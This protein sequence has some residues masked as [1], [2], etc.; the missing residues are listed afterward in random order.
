MLFCWLHRSWFSTKIRK[1][2]SF[3]LLFYAN[4]MFQRTNKKIALVFDIM[5]FILWTTHTELLW[6]DRTQP[7]SSERYT[8]VKSRSF[9]SKIELSNSFSLCTEQ[10]E[11]HT[12]T[13]THDFRIPNFS[14][15]FPTQHNNHPSTH[16]NK[17]FHIAALEQ[18]PR[19]VLDG[20]MTS[21]F[22]GFRAI[23]RGKKR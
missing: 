11:I 16:H 10:H 2:Q 4:Y 20:K 12:C 23:A 21:D 15:N 22:A 17:H 14:R 7:I 5:N 19:G 6:S 8:I 13:Q 9:N 1:A 18:S 3:Y